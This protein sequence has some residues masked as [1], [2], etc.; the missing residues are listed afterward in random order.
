MYFPFGRSLNSKKP[1]VSLLVFLITDGWSLS[2]KAKLAK[3]IVCLVLRSISFPLIVCAFRNSGI[4]KNRQNNN[5]GFIFVCL[6]FLDCSKTRR[7]G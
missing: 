3:G 1:V 4:D 5:V 7:E 2:A 6:D